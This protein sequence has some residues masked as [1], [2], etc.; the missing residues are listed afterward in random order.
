MSDN[1]NEAVATPQQEEE[2]PVAL[3]TLSAHLLDNGK[4]DVT[5]TTSKLVPEMFKRAVFTALA[6]EL[7]LA[8]N[9]HLTQHEQKVE[10]VLYGM[11]TILDSQKV[12]LEKHEGC[13]HKADNSS[14]CSDILPES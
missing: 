3:S 10:A 8:A 7:E 2:K 11:K 12:Q 13:E 6:K 9:E 4:I 14:C 1:Q 5:F